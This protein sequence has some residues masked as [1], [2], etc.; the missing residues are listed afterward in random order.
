MYFADNDIPEGSPLPK[1]CKWI[2]PEEHVANLI[3][4]G[5]DNLKD[6]HVDVFDSDGAASNDV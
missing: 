1:D 4:A 6:K 5:N 3:E 2:R